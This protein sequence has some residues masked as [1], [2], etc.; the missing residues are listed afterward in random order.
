[1][2]RISDR[3][4]WVAVQPL[5]FALCA[6]SAAQAPDTLPMPPAATGTGGTGRAS[7]RAVLVD[8]R[9]IPMAG[10]GA[11]AAGMSGG[12][13][14]SG[15]NVGVAGLGAAGGGAGNSAGAASA[16][17]GGMDASSAGASGGGSSAA[18]SSGSGGQPSAGSNAVSCD[19]G[20]HACSGRCAAED[21]VTACGALCTVCRSPAHG[22]ARCEAGACSADCEDGYLLCPDAS[23]QP[24]RFRFES[25]TVEG[26]TIEPANSLA[27]SGPPAAATF[28]GLKVLRAGMRVTGNAR[29][30]MLRVDL[31]PGGTPIDQQGKTFSANVLL[32][33]PALPT[34]TGEHSIG[35]HVWTST[36]SYYVGHV[37]NPGRNT[38]Y[39]V[40]GVLADDDTAAL[41]GIGIY[42]YLNGSAD[43]TGGVVVDDVHLD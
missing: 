16:G 19:P 29:N 23:C 4:R 1:M 43:W 10:T 20:E 7:D 31:C 11:S 6:C 13:S 15:T 36:A 5:W 24:Q 32:D 22:V 12:A 2:P 41:Q 35:L 17:T 27:S 42:V 18:G 38:W 28:E 21:D 33:G 25:S 34:T 37:A 14:G 3:R 26:F 30:L 40:S 9:L 8:D 39:T